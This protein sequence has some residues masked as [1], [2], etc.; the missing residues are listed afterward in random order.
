MMAVL[1][2]IGILYAA[3][4][5][6]AQ[7][8]VK[9][10]VAYSSVS[11]LGFCMLGLFS[12][13]IVGVSGAV[14]YMI[15][16]GLSTG[17]LFLVV[18]YVYE[19]YHTRDMGEIGGLARRMPWLAFFLVFFA[20]SSI[21]LPGLNGFVGEFL[22][23]LGAATS[24]APLH[25][26]PAGPLGF[27]YV[28]PAALGII[29][30]AVY[31]LWMCRRVLFGPLKEPPHTPDRSTGLAND[32]TRR[33]I[34]IAAPLALCCVV[35]GVFPK[36]LLTT[37]ESAIQENILHVSE[38]RAAPVE[39]RRGYAAGATH[40]NAKRSAACQGSAHANQPPT[41][42]RPSSGRTAANSPAL[43]CWGIER[44]TD[45]RHV[46]TTEHRSAV[47]T[48]LNIIPDLFPSV[49]T[50]GYSQTVPTARSCLPPSCF[51]ANQRSGFLAKQRSATATICPEQNRRLGV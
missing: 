40:P 4:A 11:H 14:L 37:F 3:L 10:L 18:G 31:M 20:L 46:G 26:A 32:L 33:E 2:I 22:V 21:G 36:P 27:G 25:R 6:W 47:P 39:A 8:D 5:A 15:N 34:A 12:L 13:Q 45:Q 38:P 44:H 50:L 49:K 51:P 48:G 43:Q 30:S 23:L 42:D 28:V 35:L 41:V 7:K 1:A 29:L 17:A 9:K 19:R 16:H 24:A